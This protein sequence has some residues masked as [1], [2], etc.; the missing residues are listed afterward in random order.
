MQTHK[1]A[2]KDRPQQ[3]HLHQQRRLQNLNS[4]VYV[5]DSNVTVGQSFWIQCIAE[6]PIEWFKDDEPIRL[7][8]IRHSK[9]DYNYAQTDVKTSQDTKLVKST[10]SVNHALRRHSGKYKCSASHRNFHRLSV[11]DD[12]TV[13]MRSIKDD[14]DEYDDDDDESDVKSTMMIFVEAQTEANGLF[15]SNDAGEFAESVTEKISDKIF[16]YFDASTEAPPLKI[17]M[18][19]H[20]IEKMIENIE[21]STT[22]LA[23]TTTN[24]PITTTTSTPTIKHHHKGSHLSLIHSLSLS[25][26]LSLY[27]ALHFCQSA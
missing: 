25:R 9:E 6:G 17:D 5:G 20:K 3:Q 24:L 7:H 15:S 18:N 14:D 1:K 21:T 4:V 27:L 16:D 26:S 11:M 2:S 23:E 10:L 22:N 12:K 8:M 13:E 19:H